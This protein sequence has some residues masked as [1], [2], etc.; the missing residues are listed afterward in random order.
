MDQDSSSE[1][2][3][4]EDA[5]TEKKAKPNP[6]KSQMEAF[7]ESQAQKVESKKEKQERI[8]REKRERKKY[9]RERNEQ[10]GKMLART[11]KG[12]PKMATQMD[13][14]LS[15]IQKNLQNEK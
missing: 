6:Y 5:R 13:V 11:K 3:E 15:K 1:E 10:R 2:E 4:E 9:Y 14:L 12:Q 8:E 7:Q